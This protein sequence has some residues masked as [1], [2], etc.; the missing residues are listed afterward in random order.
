MVAP[1]FS[2]GTSGLSIGHV[3]PE[4]AGGGL[5]ALV[6]DGDEIAIDI[7]QRSIELLLSPEELDARRIEQDK[8]DRPYTPANRERSVSAALRA[9]ASMATS[10]SDGAYRRVP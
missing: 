8:R 10:A 1:R 5:I 9:Y 6:R 2:G 3:S 7:P 4:A